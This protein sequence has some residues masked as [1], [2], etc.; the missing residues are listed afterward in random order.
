MEINLFNRKQLEIDTKLIPRKSSNILLKV[1]YWVYIELKLLMYFP[2]TDVEL[3]RLM[4]SI[5]KIENKNNI[6]IKNE[7]G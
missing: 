1:L 4:E 7:K 2:L 5:E 6:G 3:I